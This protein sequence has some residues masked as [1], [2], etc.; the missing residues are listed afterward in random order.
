MNKGAVFCVILLGLGIFLW[1]QRDEIA[2]H[3]SGTNSAPRAVQPVQGTER[4]II[5]EKVKPGGYIGWHATELDRMTATARQTRQ[6]S[7]YYLICTE[8]GTGT[9][10]IF[11][12]SA[13][14]FNME[15]IGNVLTAQQV[16]SF[17]EVSSIEEPALPSNYQFRRRE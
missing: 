17:Q 8:M 2:V 14:A 3:Q 4:F 16:R 13:S 12:V 10:R 5:R 6:A 9:Q 15:R 1:F 11:L 7:N